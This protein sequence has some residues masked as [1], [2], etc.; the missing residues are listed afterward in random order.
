MDG[1]RARRARDRARQT[2]YACHR[3]RRFARWLGFRDAPP[4]VGSRP[5]RMAGASDINRESHVKL[6]LGPHFY[7][8]T[9]GETSRKNPLQLVD[10]RVPFAV[11]PLASGT[12]VP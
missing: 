10:T 5:S 7:L 4:E 9:L 11:I 3:Q 8:S 1:T 12:S 6:T 2:W